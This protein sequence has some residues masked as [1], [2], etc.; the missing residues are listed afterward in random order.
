MI[1]NGTF[2]GVWKDAVV[3]LRYCPDISLE[4]FRRKLTADS[5]SE[6]PV[7][8]W[9]RMSSHLLSKNMKMKIWRTL[10]LPMLSCWYET[11]SFT[12]REGHRLRVFNNRVTRNIFGPRRDEITGDWRKLHNEDLF[13]LYYLPD[14][15]WV[16]KSR[17]MMRVGHVAC[18]G[19]RRGVHRVLL[20][21]PE[22]RSLLGRPRHR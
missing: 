21:K 12:L 20:G 13:G 11:W 14:N 17:I 6:M 8:I 18:M 15:N 2:G 22:G 9:S 19:K 5:T 16:I 10:T 7:T 3:A 4:R 1:M